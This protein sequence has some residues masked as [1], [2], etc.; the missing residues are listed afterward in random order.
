MQVCRYNGS[1]DNPAPATVEH[2]GD[3]ARTRQTRLQGASGGGG[4][5]PEPKKYICGR[6]GS[7]GICGHTNVR[8]QHRELQDTSNLVTRELSRSQRHDGEMNQGAR[9]RRMAD[10]GCRWGWGWRWG[11]EGAKFVCGKEAGEVE[12]P[13][14]ALFGRNC[15]S[16]LR[17]SNGGPVGAIMNSKLGW[18]NGTCGH[19]AWLQSA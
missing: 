17:K 11:V 18:L 14:N 19:P 8:R 9:L 13:R 6:G 3:G 4:R 1:K 15:S 7:L 5:R 16:V 2:T 12:E 10:A